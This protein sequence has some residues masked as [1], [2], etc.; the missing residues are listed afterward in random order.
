MQTDGVYINQ[1]WN[2]D[3]NGD[4]GQGNAAH[5][6][7]K[8]RRLPATYFSGVDANGTDSY[9]TPTASNVELK[10]TSGIVY[11]K[12]RHTF[13]AFDTSTGDK[14]LVKNWSGDAYHDITNLFDITNDSTG[15]AIGNNKYFNLVVWGVANKTGQYEPVLVNLPGGSYNTQSAAE[16][17]T[18]GFDDV[19]IPKEFK[20]ESS[21]GFL[22]ARMTIKMGATWDVVSTIDLR[23]LTPQAATGGTAAGSQVNF[24]DNVFTIFDE[25][26]STKIGA[27]D[28][29]TNITTGNTRTV[30]WPDLDGT[31]CL[32]EQDQSFTGTQT[33][34]WLSATSSLDLWF[35]T[36]AGIDTSYLTENTNLYYTDVRVADY[37]NSSTTIPVTS[38]NI[39][40]ATALAANPTDC[41]A[42]QFADAIAA[43]GDLTCNAIIDAD[44]P[45]ALTISGGTINNS[46]IGGTTP[47]AGEFTTASSTS[48]IINGLYT[49]NSS[50]NATS[51]RFT[52]TNGTNGVHI[53]PAATTTLEFF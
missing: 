10:S 22:V 28:I 8:L 9:L 14:V 17:D 6:G 37:L 13:S 31:M 53:I 44:V 43:N 26:D 36:S 51:S 45:D 46:V 32:L 41:S 42:N 19:T 18:S 21:T 4:T 27:F 52:I 24:A 30:K 49:V 5:V 3:A 35:Q 29:G 34:S 47:V 39:A 40:T 7:E 20:G 15:S 38:G 33:F 25:T 11:Q 12:H 48:Y 1:N 16:N 2:D 23:G 50:G